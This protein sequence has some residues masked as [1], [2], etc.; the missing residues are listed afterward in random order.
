MK[1]EAEDLEI[2]TFNDSKI[3]K[4]NDSEIQ[5]FKNST[6]PEFRISKI[7]TFEHLKEETNSTNNAAELEEKYSRLHTEIGWQNR[8]WRGVQQWCVRVYRQGAG[9]GG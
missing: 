3:Q 7:Q 2:Q 6:I 4:F 5:I 9:F 1:S 8:G